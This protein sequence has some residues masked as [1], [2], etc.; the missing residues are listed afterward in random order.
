MKDREQVEVVCASLPSDG[1]HGVVCLLSAG[2]ISSLQLLSP[3]L[4][5]QPLSVVCSILLRPGFSGAGLDSDPASALD[6]DDP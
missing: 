5:K 6:A 1:V 4:F 3:A 2:C